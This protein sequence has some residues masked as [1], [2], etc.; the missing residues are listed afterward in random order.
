MT[1]APAAD[2]GE[3][4]PV[5]T[6]LPIVPR[7]AL[8]VYAMY[9]SCQFRNEQGG[10]PVTSVILISSR[11]GLTTALS[12]LRWIYEIRDIK[13]RASCSSIGH[14]ILGS[15]AVTLRNVPNVP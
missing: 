15:C 13:S 12:I 2:C 11:Y 1:H 14:E 8:A 3:H 6:Y 9:A 7:P 4:A 10:C 5:A